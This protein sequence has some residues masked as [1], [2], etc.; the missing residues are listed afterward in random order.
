[1]AFFSKVYA[2]HAERIFNGL[3]ETSGGDLS[4]FVVKSV[5]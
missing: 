2:Q 5:T 4:K 3:A 1:M